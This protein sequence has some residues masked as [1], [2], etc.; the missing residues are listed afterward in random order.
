MPVHLVDRFFFFLILEGKNM[1]AQKHAFV[2]QTLECDF[3]TGTVE[4]II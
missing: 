2:E 3:S 4:R 1:V